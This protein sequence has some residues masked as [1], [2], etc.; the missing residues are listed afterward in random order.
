VIPSSARR[1]ALHDFYAFC[2]LADD[3]SDSEELC[4]S[5]AARHEAL[6]RLEAWL[7]Q[8]PETQ[9]SYWNRFRAEILHYQLPILALKG[10]IAGVRY[11]LKEKPLK[12]ETWDDLNSYVKGVAC[13][14]GEVVLAVLGVIGPKSVEYALQM[15]RSLQYLNILRDIE[16][17]FKQRKI[18]IPLE[19]LRQIGAS[20]GVLEGR[21]RMSNETKSNARVEIFERAYGFRRKAIKFSWRCLPAELMSGIYW[22]AATQYWRFGKPR[23]LSKT[24][25]FRAI[26]KTIW[27]FFF[28]PSSLSNSL[29]LLNH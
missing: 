12:F 19:F 6:N 27:K 14:V 11:D 23:R 5:P 9:N 26:T 1:Q 3:I 2:R 15:G 29:S 25:K 16:E 10:I 24:E 17:D 20:Q 8:L 4:L 22:Q 7:E 13:C 28:R 18:F 21:E